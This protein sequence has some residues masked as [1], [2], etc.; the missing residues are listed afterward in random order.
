MKTITE[1]VSR[2]RLEAYLGQIVLKVGLESLI[3]SPDALDDLFR[4]LSGRE[5]LASRAISLFVMG[6]PPT[7]Q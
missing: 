7:L 3:V 4:H 6:L 2:L 5:R 1:K